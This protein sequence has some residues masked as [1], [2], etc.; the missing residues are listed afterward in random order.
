MSG[1]VCLRIFSLFISTYRLLPRYKQGR[2][3]LIVM[4]IDFL[5]NYIFYF[6]YNHSNLLVF[7]GP[8]DQGSICDS[9]VHVYLP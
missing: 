1:R 7:A 9:R 6:S 4:A 5:F 8:N 3:I 2:R